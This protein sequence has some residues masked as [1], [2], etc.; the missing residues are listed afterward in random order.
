MP[1]M[2]KSRSGSGRG[3]NV[4]GLGGLLIGDPVLANAAQLL[5]AA[6]E[7]WVQKSLEQNSK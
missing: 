1:T 2:S 5:I 3:G 4:P 6:G 7:T